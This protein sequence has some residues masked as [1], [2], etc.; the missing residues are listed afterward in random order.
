MVGRSCLPHMR[1]PPPVTEMA[2]VTVIGGVLLLFLVELRRPEIPP[3]TQPAVL[4]DM[5]IIVIGE[6]GVNVGRRRR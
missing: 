5:S 6:S 2:D 4:E 3:P 1:L